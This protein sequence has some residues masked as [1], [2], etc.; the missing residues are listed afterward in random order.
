[1]VA[2]SDVFSGAFWQIGVGEEA[3]KRDK[4]WVY[5]IPSPHPP[6]RGTFPR[7]REKGF[8]CAHFYI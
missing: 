5:C 3:A 6:L 2:R 4:F 7:K 8:F 1:M